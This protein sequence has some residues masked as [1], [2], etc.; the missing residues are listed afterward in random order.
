MSA[1]SYSTGKAA[2][3]LGISIPTLQRKCDTGEIPCF[4]TTGGHRRIPADAVHTLLGNT[5]TVRTRNPSAGPKGRVPEERLKS[6]SQGL[7][8]P[9]EAEDF[10]VEPAKQAMEPTDTRSYEFAGN[11]DPEAAFLVTA[12]PVRQVS[13]DRELEEPRRRLGEFHRRWRG[14]AADLLPSW[15]NFEQH[16]AAVESLD[17]V[18]TRCSEQDEL[19][20]PRVL[21]DAVVRLLAPLERERSTLMRRE[22]L[23]QRPLWSLSGSASALEKGQAT[24]AIREAMSD[25]AASLYGE[26]PKR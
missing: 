15:L 11:V 12:G 13:Q 14:A 10:R 9:V 5:P 25:I 1:T 19:R 2:R 22:G 26:K 3:R 7:R 17:R 16:E 20:M 8:T 4:F 18:I 23:L 21:R 6:A 24:S